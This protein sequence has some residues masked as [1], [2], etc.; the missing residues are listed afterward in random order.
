MILLCLEVRSKLI[1][2]TIKIKNHKAYKIYGCY[3]VKK[4]LSDDV[5]ID[6]HN[7]IEI[8]SLQNS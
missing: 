7:F 8:M 3:K 6:I 1:E 5:I 2:I 4:N